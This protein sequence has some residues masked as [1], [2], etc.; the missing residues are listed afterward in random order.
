MTAHRAATAYPEDVLTTRVR[1]VNVYGHKNGDR[2]VVT[3]PH[4]WVACDVVAYR[5]P[6]SVMGAGNPDEAWVWDVRAMDVLGLE[7]RVR[8]GSW[9]FVVL[10]NGSEGELVMLVREA[11]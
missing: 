6:I 5:Q 2:C 3:V 11:A 9:A 1:V 10:P 4:E 8:G 7:V